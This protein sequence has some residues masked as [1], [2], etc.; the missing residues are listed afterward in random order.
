MA[1]Q[2]ESP[3][4]FGALKGF[5]R[6]VSNLAVSISA[7][8]MDL[9]GGSKDVGSPTLRDVQ[10]E[11]ERP[12]STGTPKKK[13]IEADNAAEFSDFNYWRTTP[14]PPPALVPDVQE[15]AAK[16]YNEMAFWRP[17][18]PTLAELEARSSRGR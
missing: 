13:P 3:G 6:T 12:W 17:V 2:P 16:E 4:V 10:T 5:G 18:Q 15:E 9:L 7:V 1:A 8:P 11:W 14:L